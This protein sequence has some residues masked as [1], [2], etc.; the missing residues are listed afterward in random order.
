VPESTAKARFHPCHWHCARRLEGTGTSPT[1]RQVRAGR[2]GQALAAPAKTL[3]EVGGVL[4]RLGV[5]AGGEYHW[6]RHQEQDEFFYVIDGRP[7]IEL[8]GRDPVELAP[9]MAFSVPRGM[10]HRP[11]ALEP[12]QVLM[13]EKTGVAVTGD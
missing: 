1:A 8:E 3:I 6:H 12:T 4:L 5:F 2:R 13:I 11:V 9:G 10:L 7:R